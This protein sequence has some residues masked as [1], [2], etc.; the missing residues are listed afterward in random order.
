MAGGVKVVKSLVKLLSGGKTK[1]KIELRSLKSWYLSG[2]QSYRPFLF[3]VVHRSLSC[4]LSE[5]I[6][7]QLASPITSSDPPYVTPIFDPLLM[8]C[9]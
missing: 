4:E 7:D 2:Y 1:F 5:L 6:L 8:A 9:N 3:R